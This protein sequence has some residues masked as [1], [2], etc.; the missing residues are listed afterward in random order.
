MWSNISNLSYVWMAWWL[1]K[2]QG[3]IY[4][5]SPHINIKQKRN[6]WCWQ[7]SLEEIKLKLW[8][9]IIH[10][11]LMYLK[12]YTFYCWKGRQNY[13][14]Q[15]V[16]LYVWLLYYA[17]VTSSCPDTDLFILIKD[18]CTFCAET[19]SSWTFFSSSS[20]TIWIKRKL[21]IAI[22]LII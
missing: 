17:A 20:C 13:T 8:I 5:Y 11:L 3:K 19:F 22:I 1:V 14:T 15:C 21:L 7:Q 9:C 10:I 12:E 4:L 18:R 16:W 6:I 2:H